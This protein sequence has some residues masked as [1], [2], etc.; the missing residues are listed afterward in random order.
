[1]PQDI[2]VHDARKESTVL[3]TYRYSKQLDDALER[4]AKTR[5][6]SPNALVSMIFTK[7]TNWD[8]YAEKFGYVGVTHETLRFLLDALDVEKLTTAAGQ[9][10]ARVPKEAVLFWFKKLDVETFLSYLENLCN[11]AGQARYD[12]QHLEGQHVITLRHELGMKWSYWLK[13]SLDAALRKALQIVAEFDI[14]EG[15]VVCKFPSEG[16]DIQSH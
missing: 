15:V 9:Q 6:I 13:Y 1:L 12:Y 8:R 2:A 14:S 3:K 16:H 10:G 11:Y 7:Y 5:G 4:E